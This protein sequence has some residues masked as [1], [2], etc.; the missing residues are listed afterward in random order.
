MTIGIIDVDGHNWPNLALMKL[1][2]YHKAIGDDV[3]WWNGFEYYDVV[4]MSK[5]FDETYSADM[6]EPVNA[7]RIVKGGT[8]YIRRK[9]GELQYFVNGIWVPVFSLEGTP[10]IRYDEALPEEVEHAYPDYSLYPR[11]TADTAY[12]HL[13]RGCPNNCPFCVVSQKEGCIARKVADLS[14]FWRGQKNI[15]LMDANLLA[16]KGHGELLS[17]LSDSGACVDFTQGLDCRR[18]TD[19]NIAVLQNIKVKEL[20]FAW[21]M[22][23]HERAV[24]AGL[25]RYLESDPHK[26][27]GAY[28]TVY[29]L[30]NYDTEHDYDLYRV[31]TLR[32]MGYDPYVMVYD[33]PNAPKITRDLQRWVNNRRIFRK[34]RNFEEYVG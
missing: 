15:K 25:R 31:Y 12:G 22:Q 29:M 34:C 28:A 23:R 33:K 16:C 27:H 30:T 7:K 21:D 10:C 17:Q 2:G 20:H 1:S 14:E 24:L 18:L 19:T 13:T 11:H 5:V 6:P 8:G 4:Y 32:D 26:L 3:R 9:N